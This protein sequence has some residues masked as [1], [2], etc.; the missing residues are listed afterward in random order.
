MRTHDGASAPADR[1][2]IFGLLL[3]TDYV[4]LANATSRTI[5]RAAFTALIRSVSAEQGLPVGR[6]SWGGDGPVSGSFE[7]LAFM[8]FDS[9]LAFGLPGSGCSRRRFEG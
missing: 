9:L 7:S 3:V 4:S 2:W 6:A 1:A 8:R 5:Q